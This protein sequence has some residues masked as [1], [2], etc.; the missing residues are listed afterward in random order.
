MRFGVFVII[1]LLASPSILAVSDV[2]AAINRGSGSYE[3]DLNG[4]K[5]GGLINVFYYMPKIFNKKSSIPK[6]LEI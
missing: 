4:E 1:V 5:P 2:P 3:V 6:S